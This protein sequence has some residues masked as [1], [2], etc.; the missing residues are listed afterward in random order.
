MRPV[1]QNLKAAFCTNPFRAPRAAWLPVPVFAAA[2]LGIGFGSG[3]F[4][5]Q[6]LSSPTAPFLPFTMFVF[7]ALLEELFF[8]GILIPR[9][10]LDRGR[11]K[12][13]LAILAGTLAFVVWHPLNA[14]LF[15]PAVIPFF[16]NPA[17]LGITAALGITCGIGYVLSRSIWV[18][19]LIHWMTV[20]VWVFLLGGTNKLL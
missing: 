5:T 18:P 2:A 13:A 6:L 20:L 3:L 4:E 10:I 15:D 17:F 14:L 7:P 1:Y 8:R 11:Q 16:F 19:V 12:A 9:D